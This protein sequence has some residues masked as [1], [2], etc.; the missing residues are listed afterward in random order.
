[1]NLWASAGSGEMMKANITRIDCDG[2]QLSTMIPPCLML[3][4]WCPPGACGHLGVALGGCLAPGQDNENC[5]VLC[6]HHGVHECGSRT[7]SFPAEAFGDRTMKA[8][9]CLQ[10][11][12]KLSGLTR[13]FIHLHAPR[14]SSSAHGSRHLITIP[15]GLFHLPQ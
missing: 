6:Q 11:L 7:T 12:A 4:C 1:M 14:A 5:P 8:F 2:L 10:S 15:R 3:N 9:S 13:Q